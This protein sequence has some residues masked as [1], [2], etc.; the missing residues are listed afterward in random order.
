MQTMM[1]GSLQHLPA[2]TADDPMSLYGYSNWDRLIACRDIGVP[3][4]GY[5]NPSR[6]DIDG[7]CFDACS[8]AS[9]NQSV[10]RQDGTPGAL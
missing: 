6:A 9:L 8:A 1:Q 3:S 5:H 10:C 4:K 7:G 2:I